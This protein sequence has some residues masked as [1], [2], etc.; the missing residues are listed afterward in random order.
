MKPGRNGPGRERGAPRAES[1]LG[2]KS[3][4]RKARRKAGNARKTPSGL[5]NGLSI[6]AIGVVIAMGLGGPL[7]GVLQ[8]VNLAA[9][10]LMLVGS[11]GIA[12]LADILAVAATAGDE[13]PFNAMASKKVPGARESIVIVR[14]AGRVNSL[15]ADVIGDI[16]GTISGVVAT[17]IIFSLGQTYPQVPPALIGMGVLGII[18]FVTIGGKAAEKGF[19]VNASTTVILFVGKVIYYLKRLTVP[20]RQK[21]SGR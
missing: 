2:E 12:I 16:C 15:C 8:N 17:P 20:F 18:A 9:G 1:G 14:N 4:T 7:G 19:S 13:A 5:R 6:G 10:A 11:I 3:A 21:R